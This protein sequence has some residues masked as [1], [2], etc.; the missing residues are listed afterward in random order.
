MK[1]NELVF[2][3]ARLEELPGILAI[4]REF[5]SD[6]D[7]CYDLA[8]LQKWYAHNPEMFYVVRY[9]ASAIVA[10]L[11]FV[12]IQETLHNA[13][14]RGELCDLLDFPEEQVCRSMDSEWYFM[15]DIAIS[16]SG[17]FPYLRAAS[18]LFGG[19]VRLGG[20][21]ANYVTSCPITEAG[22]KLNASLGMRPIAEAKHG[23]TV[24]PIY[25]MEITDE[26]RYRTRRF[27]KQ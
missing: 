27:L 2:A 6:I 20:R 9:G 12:P 26:K 3:A 17:G 15:A 8:F 22:V 7:V 16:A 14:L 23:D 4:E 19:L 21:L 25:Y 10:F 18:K 1:D 5:F 11:I 24:Y 13:L